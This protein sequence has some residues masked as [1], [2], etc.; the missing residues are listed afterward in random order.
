VASK[1]VFVSYSHPDRERVRPLVLLLHRKLEPIGGSVFWDEQLAVGAPLSEWV[2]KLLSEAACVVVVWTHTSV[3]SQ[4]VH[5]ECEGARKD[6]RL[7]PV[8]I[9]ANAAIPPPFNALKHAELLNWTGD[10]GPGFAAI[11][12]SILNLLERGGGAPKMYN[13]LAEIPYIIEDA[14]A[15]SGELRTLAGRFRSI[16]EVLVANSPPVQDLRESLEQVMATY[17][18][19]NKALQR[20]MLP[21]LKPGAL[22]PEAYVKL[23]HGNLMQEIEAGRGH[24]GQILIHYRRVG[25]VRDAI[26]GRLSAT[27]LEEVD[28]TFEQLGTADGDA[29]ARMTRIGGYLADESRAVINHLFAQQDAAARERVA[30]TRQLLE[31][32]ERE[33]SAGMRELQQLEASLGGTRAARTH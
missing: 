6:G 26:Q 9:D 28:D 11:W 15:A 10:D 31:P 21:A 19:V 1:L 20:F 33:L 4:W 12:I 23:A 27:E 18:V 32:L 22:D 5:G 24:C 3:G 16:G 25:G 14:T 30:A 13:S 7:V 8:A 17:S 29:F 2:Q